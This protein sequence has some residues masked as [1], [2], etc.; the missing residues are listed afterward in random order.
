MHEELRVAIYG[1]W[2]A[3]RGVGVLTLGVVVV[4]QHGKRCRSR[5]WEGSTEVLPEGQAATRSAPLTLMDHPGPDHCLSSTER[6]PRQTLP[7]GDKGTTS[8]GDR[9]HASG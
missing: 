9:W 4:H 8:S 3:S 5:A 7:V 2:V 1:W 6:H